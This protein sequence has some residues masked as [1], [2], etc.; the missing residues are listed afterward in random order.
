MLVVETVVRI[1]REYAKG[2][3]IKAICRDL[4]LSRQVVRKA[5][6]GSEGEFGYQRTVQPF[7]KLGPFLGRLDELL[8]QNALASRRERLTLKRIW[9]LLEREG[10]EASYDAVRRYAVR[11]REEA[12][13]KLGD[14][15]L[16]F[17][18]LLFQPGEAFQFDFS[19]E[20]VEIGGQQARVKVAHMRLCASRAVYLRAYPRETQEMVFDA[21]PR[22]ST[23]SPRCR[24]ARRV[25]LSAVRPN[26][27]STPLPPH[28]QA[29]RE[30]FGDHH[31]E[32]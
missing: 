22:R 15:S 17:V 16:A 27:R 23:L 3:A 7:P 18:P 13:T 28:Q 29:L 4:K 20:D 31:D 1:R 24:G 30:N 32:P 21:Q 25:G 5:I 8:A 11:W 19:H 12:K 9:D 10:C 26:R 6:R 14:V 2:K